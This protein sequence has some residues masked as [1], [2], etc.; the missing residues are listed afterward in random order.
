MGAKIS[1]RVIKR[2]EIRLKEIRN[3]LSIFNCVALITFLYFIFNLIIILVFNKIMFTSTKIFYYSFF[4]ICSS[5]LLFYIIK[6][7][8]T[9]IHFFNTYYKFVLKKLLRRL[10][11][12]TK[13][14]PGLLGGWIIFVLSIIGLIIVLIIYIA[15]KE[16]E[17]F[18]DS[19]LKFFDGICL[20]YFGS[21]LF[22]IFINVIPDK[23]KK[24]IANYELKT[25]K[26]EIINKFNEFFLVVK[27]FEK[28]N[29]NKTQPNGIVY[30]DKYYVFKINKDHIYFINFLNELKKISMK[31]K[32]L[33]VQI[34]D[35]KYFE[36]LDPLF[37]QEILFFKNNSYLDDLINYENLLVNDKAGNYVLE[38]I[39]TGHLEYLKHH[40]YD[41]INVLK[42]NRIARF[43]IKGLTDTEIKDFLNYLI[44]YPNE[45]DEEVIKLKLDKIDLTDRSPISFKFDILKDME[46]DIE[47]GVY[48]KDH[49]FEEY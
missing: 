17:N 19:I 12:R 45:F 10:I 30:D 48:D 43:E 32:D 20:A 41:L 42:I 23:K 6:I 16:T 24:R 47:R 38:K 3:S 7:S 27:M 44:D 36:Y 4:A 13:Q 29:N 15:N 25:I 9:Y 11:R 37:V 26:Y 28:L 31:V 18:N 40:F 5:Y 35:D 1:E 14:S 33:L 2:K 39:T 22:Y 21:F 34:S 49:T 8:V 46:Y